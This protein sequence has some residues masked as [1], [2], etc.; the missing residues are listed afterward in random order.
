VIFGG[1]NDYKLIVIPQGVVH[2]YQVLSDDPVFLFY[3]V[4]ELYEPKNPDEQRIPHDD[5]RIHFDWTIT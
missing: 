3:H 2:G 5:S 4:T 1:R